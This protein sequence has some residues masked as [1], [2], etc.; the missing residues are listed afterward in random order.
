MPNILALRMLVVFSLAPS[1]LQTFK[2]L[3]YQHT[4]IC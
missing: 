2:R 3:N 4:H 1:I